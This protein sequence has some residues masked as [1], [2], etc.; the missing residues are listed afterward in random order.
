MKFVT[1]LPE[2]GQGLTRVAMS[3]DLDADELNA[4]GLL[5]IEVTG[6]SLGRDDL[7]DVSPALGLRYDAVRISKREPGDGAPPAQVSGGHTVR[8]RTRRGWM[9]IVPGPGTTS[10]DLELV[11]APLQLAKLAESNRYG[12]LGARV[13]RKGTNIARTQLRQAVTSLGP[14]SMRVATDAVEVLDLAGRPLRDGVSVT[15]RKGGRLT[16]ELAPSITAPVIVRLDTDPAGRRAAGFVG[17]TE[18]AIVG[19]H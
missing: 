7:L 1:R 17:K 5:M 12:K 6:V 16:I 13:V 19:V 14:A 11:D 18:W 9:S 10:V 2:D 15:A 4:E 8:A 3:F